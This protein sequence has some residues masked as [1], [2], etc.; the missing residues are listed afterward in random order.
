MTDSKYDIAI[1]FLHQDEQLAIELESKL[2][3]IFKVFIYSKKQE[4]I[5]GT[6][7]LETFR[8][9]FRFE[10][11]LVVIL[12]RDGWGKSKWTRV[13]EGAITDRFINEGWQWL[14]FV[15]LD[16]NCTPPKWLPES[17]IRLNYDEYGIEQCLGAI[18]ARVEELGGTI[19]HES[20]IDRAKRLEQETVWEEKRKNLLSTEEGVASACKEAEIFMARVESILAE[21]KSATTNVHIDFQRKGLHLVARGSIASLSIIWHQKYRNMLENS[22]VKIGQWKGQILFPDQPGYYFEDPVEYATHWYDPDITREYGWCWRSSSGKHLTS[23]QLAEHAA[24]LFI[25]TLEH[26]K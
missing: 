6:D 26:V 15:S 1:S 2:S 11:R 17:R 25:Q 8:N 3:P 23:E 22:R 19:K 7:G 13:E 12:Y 10:S 16:S 18:K 5:A 14:L 21:M 20:A 24:N 9:V 4:E